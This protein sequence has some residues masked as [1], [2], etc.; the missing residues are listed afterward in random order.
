MLNI[1][2]LQI[3]VGSGL[4]RPGGASLARKAPQPCQGGGAHGKVPKNRVPTCCRG[5]L[6]KASIALF[7]APKRKMA[8]HTEA[9]I[10]SWSPDDMTNDATRSTVVIFMENAV[11]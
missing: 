11:F 7:E 2:L 1:I 5:A 10:R 8:H 4:C 6:E 9:R 3:E